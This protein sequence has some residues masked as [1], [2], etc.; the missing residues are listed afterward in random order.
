MWLEARV[1]AVRG[2]A[3]G[4]GAAASGC[5]ATAIAFCLASDGLSC[6]TGIGADGAGGQSVA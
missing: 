4:F 5:F 1:A 3:S 6:L 2:A